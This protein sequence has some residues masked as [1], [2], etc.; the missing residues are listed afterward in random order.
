MRSATAFFDFLGH[1]ND[2]N[3]KS[4]NGKNAKASKRKQSGGDAI[5]GYIK[6]QP[7]AFAA[8]CRKL[9]AEID[10]ALP[11]A[12]S[13]IWHAIPVWFIGDNPIVGFKATP[14]NVNLLFWNGQSL[15]E[16][17]LTAAGKFRAA[18]IQFTDV[19]EIESNALRRW[20]KKAKTNIWDYSG[21]RKGKPG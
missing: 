15:G 2:P 3:M 13:K 7:P 8:I 1:S 4:A 16:P 21:I 11:K 12:V 14:K 9:R 19:S 10:A 17:A 18:Q 5:V 20:L 6:T